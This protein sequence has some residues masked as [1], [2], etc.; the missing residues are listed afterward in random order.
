MCFGPDPVARSDGGATHGQSEHTGALVDTQGLNPLGSEARYA[1]SSSVGLPATPA[2]TWSASMRPSKRPPRPNA[3]GSGSPGRP[4]C[5][6]T[7]RSSSV[8]TGRAHLQRA[9]PAP[10]RARRRPAEGRIHARAR[11]RVERPLLPRPRDPEARRRRAAT[12]CR[13]LQGQDH[14]ADPVRGRPRLPAR[15]LPRWALAGTRSRRAVLLRPD[16]QARH[17]LISTYS[18]LCCVR[19]Y[20]A[21]AWGWTRQEACARDRASRELG[22]P[23]P[24][25]RGRAVPPLCVGHARLDPS[26][27]ADRGND[28]CQG[29]RTR[30]L[31]ARAPSITG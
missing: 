19:N 2:K 29:S 4:T 23:S 28:R 12:G 15:R 9:D 25:Q 10:R 6:R 13:R 30:P 21:A 14:P 18:R 17:M 31:R 8:S 24:L 27:A 20:V 26:V 7:A 22:A 3:S 5:A 11:A 1:P 16:R